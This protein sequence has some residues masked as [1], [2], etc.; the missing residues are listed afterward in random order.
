MG[1]DG[2]KKLLTFRKNYQIHKVCGGDGIHVVI[3]K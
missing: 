1:A 2:I 3:K